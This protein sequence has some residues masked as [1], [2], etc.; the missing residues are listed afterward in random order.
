[1]DLLYHFFIISA[2]ISRKSSELNSKW[3]PGTSVDNI[4]YNNLTSGLHYCGAN[5]T[6]APENYCRVLCIYSF[7]ANRNDGIQIAFAVLSSKIYRRKY[8][9]SAGWTEWT[10]FS[11]DA[12]L[13]EQITNLKYKNINYG[14]ITIPSEG[15]IRWAETDVGSPDNQIDGTVLFATIYNW[16]SNGGHCFNVNER[17]CFGEANMTITNLNVRFWYIE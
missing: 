8:S 7:E 10:T 4:D 11:D 5:C 3:L 14:N 15:Y 6:N 17:Y 2:I 9:N 1:M 12:T 16:G 13:L